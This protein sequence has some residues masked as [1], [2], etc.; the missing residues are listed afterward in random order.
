MRELA[1]LIANGS[2]DQHPTISAAG[3]DMNYHIAQAI[4]TNVT[5]GFLVETVSAQNGLK[6]GATQ[7]T[8]VGSRIRIG[9][10]IIIGIN[11]ARISN[12]DDLLSYLEQH[13]L[14]GQ[15]VDFTVIRDGTTQTVSVTIGKLT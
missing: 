6:G 2:Y 11:G 7:I 15:K 3:T 9:G 10:D 12:T 14:P 8:V 4:E 13:T 5:Y 1:S